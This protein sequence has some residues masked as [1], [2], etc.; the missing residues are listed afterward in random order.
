MNAHFTVDLYYLMSF[1]CFDDSEMMKKAKITRIKAA[2]LSPLLLVVRQY[3]LMR[4]RVFI[5]VCGLIVSSYLGFTCLPS[6]LPFL[7]ETK[8]EN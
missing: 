1:L 8:K 4:F 3:P 6:T 2:C 5:V 7:S